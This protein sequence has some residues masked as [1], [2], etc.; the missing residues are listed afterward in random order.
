MVYHYGCLLYTSFRYRIGDIVPTDDGTAGCIAGFY[1]GITPVQ[2]KKA[3]KQ[4]RFFKNALVAP[5]RAK[6][7]ALLLIMKA[8]SLIHISRCTGR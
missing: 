4:M 8:L 6:R 5:G 1:D 7:A 2:A 3:L